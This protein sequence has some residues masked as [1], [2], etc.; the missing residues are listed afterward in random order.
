MQNLH[1]ATIAALVFALGC[2]GN[3]EVDSTGGGGAGGS[4][5]AGSQGGAAGG[6]PDG[7][8]DPV[9]VGG[10]DPGTDPAVC[11]PEVEA[12]FKNAPEPLGFGE[13]PPPSGK[14]IVAKLAPDA[15]VVQSADGQ[16]YFFQWAG[17]DLELYFTPGSEVLVYTA[18]PY[19]AFQTI[20]SPN[21]HF[22]ATYAD[23]MND[24]PAVQDELPYGK[25]DF[26]FNP[27]CHFASSECIAAYD[28][29]VSNGVSSTL[30]SPGLSAYVNSYEVR[31]VAVSAILCDLVTTHIRFT[32][33]GPTEGPQ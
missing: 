1:R 11:P 9:D 16:S 28:I 7:G 6:V 3:V 30:V 19:G 20:E 4:G 26:G 15:L 17:D 5:T 13:T 10:S 29:G 14:Y 27:V 18:G 22:V 2:N 25:L 23:E 12:A 21:Q 31:N 24:F 8:N 33:S 32:V